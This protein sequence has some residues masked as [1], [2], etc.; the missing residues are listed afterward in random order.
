MLSRLT[1]KWQQSSC[2]A[3]IRE[4]R[5]VLFGGQTHHV[6]NDALLVLCLYTSAKHQWW[7]KYDFVFIYKLYMSLLVLLMMPYPKYVKMENSWRSITI[8]SGVWHY[9]TGDAMSLALAVMKLVTIVTPS[10]HWC[11]AN[12]RVRD[13]LICMFA[14]IFNLWLSLWIIHRLQTIFACICT[15]HSNLYICWIVVVF[16]PLYIDPFISTPTLPF[17]HQHS[18]VWSYIYYQMNE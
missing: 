8:D 10:S 11:L 6:S 16:H 1:I 12:Q 14:Y 17:F 4:H 7:T 5:Y 2:V 3:K 13:T 15:R 18:F 9:V